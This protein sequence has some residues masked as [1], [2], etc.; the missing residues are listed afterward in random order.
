MSLERF[1]QIIDQVHHSTISVLTHFQGEPL[2]NT[3]IF[4]MI[5]YA[6]SKRLITEMATN[7]T[8]IDEGRATEMVK[9]GLRK[10]VITIDSVQE[11][12]FGFYRKGASFKEVEEGIRSIK[13]AK[14]K[15]KSKYPLLVLELLALESNIKQV[16]IFNRFA[17]KY[18]ADI[19]RVKTAQILSPA[20]D[21]AKIPFGTKYS[22]YIKNAKG[23][24]NLKGNPNATCSSPWF[25]LSITHDG[26]VVPCCFDKNAFYL[27][28]S[29]NHWSIKEIWWSKHYNQL[30]K[31]LLQS[32]SILPI[33]ADC[34]QNR[35]PLDYTM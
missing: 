26:W 21:E 3:N 11:S 28:G 2:M 7:A 24:I 25:K 12:S 18:N 9:S 14:L 19:I 10:V 15:T 8:L 20:E 30:R 32:R 6:T 34:P 1:K 35:M 33:C 22:R 5:R 16:D 17:K 23:E 31:R 13:E 27:M 29:V 4:E